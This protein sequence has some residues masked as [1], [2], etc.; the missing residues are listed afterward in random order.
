MQQLRSLGL[1][2]ANRVIESVLAHARVGGY[3]GVAV[4]VVDKGAAIISGQRMDGLAR[5]Y[6]DSAYRKAYTAAAME[7]DTAAVRVFWQEQQ[8]RGHQGPGDWNDPMLTTLPGGLSVVLDGE[9]VG[10]IGVAGG[11]VTGD[12]SDDAF[13]LVGLKALGEDFSHRERRG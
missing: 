13:A 11:G 10:G 12:F 8:S 6:F 7:R 2:E 9:V 4:V 1:A 5:R 3:R